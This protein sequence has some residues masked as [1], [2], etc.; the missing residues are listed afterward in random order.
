M[1][2]FEGKLY[3]LTKLRGTSILDRKAGTSLYRLDS[4]RSDEVN[5]L[6]KI[7]TH[8]DVL[9]PT[10]A[11]LS[12]SGKWLAVLGYT[13]LWIFSNPAGEDNWLSGDAR[14]L[15]LDIYFTRQGEAITW[16][17]DNRL[18]IGNEDSEWF[19]VNL[20]DIPEYDGQPGHV[21]GINQ[22]RE[23]GRSRLQ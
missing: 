8:A 2:V 17:D 22:I 4:M 10:A 11:D 18:L 15:P 9:F 3:F 5:V 12:P 14:R 23:F 21:E 13:E 20:A 7:D 6:T 16:M 1:F 19:T